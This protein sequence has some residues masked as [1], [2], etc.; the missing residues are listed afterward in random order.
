MKHKLQEKNFS[1]RAKRPREKSQ[2]RRIKVKISRGEVRDAFREK[3]QRQFTTLA[4]IYVDLCHTIRGK[5]PKQE[6]I[7]QDEQQDLFAW[8]ERISSQKNVEIAKERAAVLSEILRDM[9][10]NIFQL[11]GESFVEAFGSL[12]DLKRLSA[13]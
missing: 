12:E 9:S 1:G 11:G 4:G 3:L 10:E 7:E 6:A 2:T 13:P 5:S 8:H